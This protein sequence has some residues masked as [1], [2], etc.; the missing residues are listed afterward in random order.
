MPSEEQNQKTEVVELVPVWEVSLSPNWTGK[1]IE[2]LAKA[3]LK[4]KPVLKTVDNA[5]F[6]RGGKASKYADLAEYIDAT[7]A[8]LAE[9]GLVVTQW[10]DVSPEAKSMSLV[11]YLMHSSGEWM[12]GK[13]TLPAIGR[14]G[15]TAQSCGSS[16]T[17]ARRYSYAAITGCA[18]EDD[19]GNAASGRGTSE[20]AKAVGEAK[21]EDLKKARQ[22]APQAQ[23]E[24]SQLCVYPVGDGFEITGDVEVLQAYKTIL[25]TYGTKSGPTT[26]KLTAEGLDT[27]KREF[28]EVGGNILTTLKGTNATR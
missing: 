27:F 20:A 8:S 21:V 1:L 3:Q 19:D 4:F 25:L 5:A 17:Y 13:L 16:I 10:P 11:S 23:H 2:A 22:K 9:N 14:D 15:F 28:V 12:R 7:Q 26:V 6:M 24:P 18:S